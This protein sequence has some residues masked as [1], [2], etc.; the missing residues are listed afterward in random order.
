[1]PAYYRA[2]RPVFKEQADEDI[3]EAMA[4]SRWAQ[5]VFDTYRARSEAAEPIVIDA[6]D[7]VHHTKP[8][9][10][11]LCALLGIDPDGVQYVWDAVTREAWPSDPIMQGFFKTLLKS[12]G[13]Q[14]DEKVTWKALWS[15][16]RY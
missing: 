7:V 4:T 14:R 2:Q 1:M 6:E 15:P 10:Q 5:M 9:I 16:S 8:L 12:H 3:F 13:V 11:K